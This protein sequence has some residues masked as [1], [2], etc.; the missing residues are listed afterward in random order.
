MDKE[1][2]ML[3]WN[4]SLEE[5]S[6][7]DAI[8]EEIKAPPAAVIHKSQG[9]L[10]MREI[11]HSNAHSEQEFTSDEKVLLFYNIPQKG[12]MFLINTFKQV[13]LPRP[14]YAVVTEHSIEWPFNEL[15]EHL[16]EERNKMQQLNAGRSRE[17]EEGE[18]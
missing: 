1:P 9:H 8:L 7:L 2:R 10:T 4:Y 12:V 11:I 15:L 14:I 16:V 17:A 6:R 13:D 18:I 5:K 3:V